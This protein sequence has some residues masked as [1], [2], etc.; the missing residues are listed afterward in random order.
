MIYIDSSYIDL[1]KEK[2]KLEGELRKSEGDFKGLGNEKGLC[3]LI[4]YTLT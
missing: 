4:L 2:R 1:M 3:C